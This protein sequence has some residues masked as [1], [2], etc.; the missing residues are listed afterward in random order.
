MNVP[1]TGLNNEATESCLLHN[2]P[3]A[4]TCNHHTNIIECMGKAYV[5]TQ[6]MYDDEG[7]PVDFLHL[8][9]NAAYETM[10]GIKQAVGKKLSAF[11]PDMLNKY[12][13][14]IAKQIRLAER[15]MAER[16]EIFLESKQTW[17]DTSLYCPE[18][19]Y[20]IAILDDITKRKKADKAL[21]KSEKRFRTLFNSHSAIQAL[22]DPDT[23]K[24]LDVNE[25]AAGWYG[26]RL[27]ELRKMY[28]RDINTL[29]PDAII[30]SLKSVHSGQHNTFSGYHR[31]AD[32]SIRDVEIFR[33]KIEIDGKAVVHAIIHDVTERKQAEAELQRVSRALLASNNCNQALLHTDDELELLQKICT[34]IVEQGGYRMAWVGYAVQ[35][36]TKSITP[37]SHAGIT[38]GYLNTLKV[39]WDSDE[40]GQGPAGT[41]IR[42]GKPSTI[43]NINQDPRFAVWLTEAKKRGYASIHSLPLKI[44]QRVLGALTIC[45]GHPDAF[46][47]KES[48]LLGRLAENLAY[49]ISMLRNRKELIKSNERFKT[50]FDSHSAFQLLLDTETGGVID[51]NQSASDYYGWPVAEFRQKFLWDICTHPKEVIISNLRNK[52]FS[53][54]TQLLDFHKKA[55]GSII[56]V[57]IFRTQ[58][59]IDGKTVLHVIIHDI[60]ERKRYEMLNA[61]RLCL[62]QMTETHSVEELLRMTLDE[63]EK[64]TGS[65]IGFI[66]FVDENQTTLNLQAWSSNTIQT[67]CKANAA[68]QHY[69]LDK[70]GVWADAVREQ[71][72]LIHNDYPSLEHRKG[73]PEG[74]AEVRREMVI[75]VIR[76]ETIVA[77]MGLGNKPAD[78]NQKDIEWVEVLAN[79]VWDIIAKKIAENEKNKLATQLQHSAKMEM[80]GQLAAGIAHEINNPLNFILLNSKNLEEDFSDLCELVN[81]YRRIIEKVEPLPSLAEEIVQ[82][83]EKERTIDIDDLIHNIPKA[84]KKSDNGVERI[85]T[86]TRSMRNFSYKN[87]KESFTP[88]DLNNAIEEALVIAK[89]EYRNLITLEVQLE[90]LPLVLCDPSK[91]SQVILNLILNSVHAIKSQNRS[92]P[93]RIE[94]KTW[95]CPENVSCSISDDGPGIPEKIQC[96]I[97][98]PFFTT[99]DIGKGTGLGLSIS[100][101]IMTNQHKGSISFECPPEKGT[102]FTFSLPRIIS[103]SA[104][105]SG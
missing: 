92:D 95:A 84:L 58:I 56:D 82:I 60:T 101:D 77:I 76:N 102:V 85:T 90:S 2:M 31:M 99:K 97:F 23:G 16:F 12:A 30:K 43:K 57:E 36:N 42:T 29:P 74:H 41:A 35:D 93:G 70:A 4:N 32:G 94:V 50:L 103:P 13:E 45:S 71:K 15:G 55:D 89:S 72:A 105:S 24:I 37:V 61:F 53:R 65:S 39:S 44:G 80:I 67:M 40:Y 26:W 63:A 14:F 69:P 91:I 7:R 46:S 21:K 78:Y 22:L 34:I 8:E 25:K 10:T 28:T 88:F 86:I 98:E 47:E 48:E 3:F 73:M 51:A 87:S 83:R 104:L 19:G 81:D 38:D 11:F 27:D 18:K 5:C 100:Y 64:I 79:Q 49:G 6:V 52:E 20:L 17:F 62:L 1:T 75:P 68:S 59:E 54:Q 33:N 66:H 9:V 96:R